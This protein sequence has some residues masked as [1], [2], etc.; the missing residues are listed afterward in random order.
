MRWRGMNSYID[1]TVGIIPIVGII[2]IIVGAGTWSLHVIPP[3]ESKTERIVAT[4]GLGVLLAL[5]LVAP[6]IGT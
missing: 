2:V 1:L 5:L 6:I 3:T 4:T